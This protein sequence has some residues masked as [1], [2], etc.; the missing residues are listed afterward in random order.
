MK[1]LLTQINLFENSGYSGFG[2]LGLDQKSADDA[3][4]IFVNVISSTIGLITLI[5]IIWFVINLLTGAVSMITSGGDKATLE[6]ARKRMM[7]GLT[8]LVITIIAVIM[9][10]FIGYLMGFENILNFTKFFESL[11][12]K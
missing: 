9:I 2:P 12:I 5:A 6:N 1:N 3:P 10:G 8:G 4:S 11:I 7:S